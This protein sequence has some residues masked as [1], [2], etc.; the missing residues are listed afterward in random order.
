M[1]SVQGQDTFAGGGVTGNPCSECRYSALCLPIGFATFF[2][3]VVLQHGRQWLATA[4]ITKDNTR[5][6]NSAW[7]ALETVRKVLPG[8]CPNVQPYHTLRVL[9]GIRARGPVVEL[10]I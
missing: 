5:I 1:F 3:T 8:E 6:R 4:D 7:L 2:D 10:R 9:M